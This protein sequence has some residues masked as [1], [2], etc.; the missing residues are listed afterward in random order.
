ME[1]AASLFSAKGVVADLDG[2][3]LDTEPLYFRAYAGVAARFGKPYSFE[4]VHRHILGRAEMAGAH[5][6][7]QI[8]ELPITPEQLLEMRDE[9]FVQLL[10][11]AK[12]LPGAMEAMGALKGAGIPMAI[13]TSSCREYLPAKSENNPQLFAVFDKVICGDDAEVK[14]HSKPDPAIFLHAAKE[15]GLAPQHC[16]AFEDSL[17]GIKSAKAAGMFTVAIPDPRLDLDEVKAAEPDLI[18]G[19]L[20]EFDLAMVGLAAAAVVS[21]TEGGSAAAG[22]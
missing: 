11:T 4:D 9:I 2:T 16:V 15:I 21:M 18:L 22:E 7:K 14:G 1:I 10:K 8:L 12:C 17:A 20:S 13:A 6:M 19:S 3:L 5:T